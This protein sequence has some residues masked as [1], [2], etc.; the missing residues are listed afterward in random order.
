MVFTLPQET[1][2]FQGTLRENIDPHHQR[3]DRDI[4]AALEACEMSGVL[5][6]KYGGNALSQELSPDGTELSAGQRQL[7][8][9]ARV[10]LEQPAVLL[11]DEGRRWCPRHRGIRLLISPFSLGKC[12]FCLRRSAAT[13]VASFAIQI[14]SYYDRSST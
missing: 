13:C 2:I 1:L 5:K 11:V 9:A 7:V 3:S 12:R 4:W 14:D 10:V 8:C 6:A